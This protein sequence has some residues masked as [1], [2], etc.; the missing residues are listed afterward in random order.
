ML[1][2]GPSLQNQGP[3]IHLL[4]VT[5]LQSETQKRTFSMQLQAKPRVT[6]IT[7]TIKCDIRISYARP[8]GKKRSILLA[9]QNSFLYYLR[10]PGRA[11]DCLISLTS[12]KSNECK[13]NL[14]VRTV[15][16]TLKFSV[17]V[18]FW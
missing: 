17:N 8:L 9:N 15:I 16:L 3:R 6:I 5:V 13:S 14:V 4:P 10:L 18:L 7:S 2:P 1:V 11:I 12:K